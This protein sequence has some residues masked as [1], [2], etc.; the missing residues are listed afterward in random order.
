WLFIVVSPKDSGNEKDKNTV[1]KS[2]ASENIINLYLFI[3]KPRRSSVQA[4]TNPKAD[5]VKFYQFTTHR[6][7]MNSLPL[8]VWID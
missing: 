4:T 2:K 8:G 5:I 3:I 1:V 7:A 6:D